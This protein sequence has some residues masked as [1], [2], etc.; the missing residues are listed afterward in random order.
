[1][2]TSAMCALPPTTASGRKNGLPGC[3]GWGNVD[4]E[5]S[6]I[7][8]GIVTPTRMESSTLRPV[9]GP[10][11][12][13]GAAPGALFAS[14][15]RLERALGEGGTGVVWAADDT[16]TGQR[17]ALKLLKPEAVSRPD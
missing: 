16:Q 5:T 4:G 11:P 10:A 12:P 14:R 1:M 3:L 9:E 13:P 15:Y 17:V 8:R 7:R 2:V 6:S